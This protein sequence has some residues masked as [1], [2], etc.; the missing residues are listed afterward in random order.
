MTAPLL[1]KEAFTQ[2]VQF[3]P[4]LTFKSA[5]KLYSESNFDDAV[6]EY[7]AIIGQGYESANLYYNLGNAYFKKG[8]LGK[9]ILNYERAKKLLPNDSDLK[10]NLA[11]AYSLTE[12]PAMDKAHIWF[13]RRIDNTLDLFT[14]D[15]LTKTLHIIYQSILLLLTIL[16]FKKGLRRI[17]VNLVFVMTIVFLVTITILSINIYRIEYVKT[18]VVTAKEEN[19]RFEPLEDATVHFKLYAGSKVRVIKTRGDW[20]QV[21]REDGKVGWVESSSYGII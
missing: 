9:A 12:E 4:Y 5:S 11:Y 14:I 1:L 18:A 19:A 17:I 10:S 3:N 7:G 15:G 13:S 2:D 6:N 16:I 20:S 8:E 21:R